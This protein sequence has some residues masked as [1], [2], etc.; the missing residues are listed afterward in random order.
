MWT[1]PTAP[2]A[3][4][5]ELVASIVPDTVSPV[6]VP[7]LVM[8]GCAAVV[9]VPAVVAVPAVATFR[10]ATCVVDDTMNGAVPVAIL[11]LKMVALACALTSREDS[12]P[13]LV[14]LGCAAVVTVPAVVAV[15]AAATFRLATC[16][17]DVTINGAVPV[18]ILDLK[19]V[20]LACALTSSAVKVPNEVILGCAA[21][22]TVPA[23]PAVAA[24]KL[25]TCVVLLTMN[26]AVP[27]ATFALKMLA[28]M[29]PSVPLIT[30]LVSVPS[31]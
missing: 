28:C 30:P 8:L 31:L 20:A 13:T 5:A 23:V 25:A 7:T 4:L 26:G 9:T 17:V 27:V 19:M 16:V 22:V 29:V 3:T 11:D 18:A 14:M 1:L 10:L 15:P 12:V 2:S 6:S 21:A 24:F